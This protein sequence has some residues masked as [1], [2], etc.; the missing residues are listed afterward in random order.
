MAAMTEPEAQ[1]LAERKAA[2]H[3]ALA[4]VEQRQEAERA[5]ERVA[6]EKAQ[7]E[8]LKGRARDLVEAE[9]RRLAAIAEAEAHM[10]AFVAAVDRAFAAGEQ[11]RRTGLEIA[12]ARNIRL[13]GFTALSAPEFE[14]RLAYGI[15]AHLS[16]LKIPGRLA[17]G[18]VG[19]LMLTGATLHPTTPGS[20]VE[21][22]RSR[23][24]ADVVELLEAEG[25]GR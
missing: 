3:Q 6:E 7:R 5:A 13:Y 21:R 15:S 25:S 14:A 9:E 2:L 8:L 1:T 10:I 22:E 17:G 18:R 23:T 16:K 11:V 24:V 4:E 12:A 19:A 20:W